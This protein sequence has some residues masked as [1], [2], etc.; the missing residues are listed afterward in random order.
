MKCLFQLE[1]NTLSFH[2]PKGYDTKHPLIIDPALIFASYS[3]AT[4]DNWGYTSTFNDL[5]NL[6]GGGI[7]FGIGYPVTTGAIQTTFGGG[8]LDISISKFSSN[9]S[10]LEYSTYFGGGNSDYPHSMIVN[11]NDE[12]LVFGTTASNNFLRHRE[13]IQQHFLELMMLM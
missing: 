10:S 11:S 12:L 13:L 1:N 4:V 5:G 2:F 8:A 6:Y 7:S 3:G 9:G